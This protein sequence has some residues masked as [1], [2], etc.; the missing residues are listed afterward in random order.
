MPGDEVTVVGRV[1]ETGDGID[2]LVVSDRP[3][4]KTIFRM[5][6]TSL[7]GLSIGLFV[8]ILGLTLFL[9]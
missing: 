7:I 2:P 5:A 1:T 9:I 4:S 6:K 3:P 8:V